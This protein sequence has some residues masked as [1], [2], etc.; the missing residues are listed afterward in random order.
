MVN[1]IEISISMVITKK[2]IKEDIND[3]AWG[4]SSSDSGWGP[5]YNLTCQ[6]Y[7]D[8]L[9]LMQQQLKA[10]AACPVTLRPPQ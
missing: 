1:K 5:S 10:D 7:H 8:L 3:C 9:I 6:T 4:D 2:F